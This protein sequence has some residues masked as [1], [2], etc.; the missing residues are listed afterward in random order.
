VDNR[1]AQPMIPALV[2]PPAAAR[3]REAKRANPRLEQR[4]RR[5]KKRSRGFSSSSI[6]ARPGAC[7][8]SRARPHFPP[9][10]YQQHRA[11]RDYPRLGQ[12]LH[13][14]CYAI[15]P[16]A[17]SAMTWRQADDRASSRQ[18]D[19]CRTDLDRALPRSAPATPSSCQNWTG[20]PALCRMCQRRREDA[21]AGRSK[22]AS[23]VLPISVT[24]NT[25]FQF[26]Q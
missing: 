18:P 10:A 11:W 23:R 9:R 2:V 7:G 1:R 5:S 4:G 24:P 14:Q 3:A 16:A 12:R 22:N 20:S 15:R 8:G 25:A 13:K 17:N 26:D 21:S 19:V 6:D